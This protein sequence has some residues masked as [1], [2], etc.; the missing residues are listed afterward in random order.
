MRARR[1]IRFKT[2]RKGHNELDRKK[3]FGWLSA[4]E[5]GAKD[6]ADS[7]GKSDHRRRIRAS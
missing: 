7:D 1:A 5:L 3:A 6:S 2:A 4:A